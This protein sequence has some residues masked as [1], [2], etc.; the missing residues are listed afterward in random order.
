MTNLV[1][2]AVNS[3]NSLNWTNQQFSKERKIHLLRLGEVIAHL[4][5]PVRKG[6]SLCV[7]LYSAIKLFIVF[8]VLVFLDF[9]FITQIVKNL[10]Y[11]EGK[12][13]LWR[14]TACS[15]V[16]SHNFFTDQLYNNDLILLS[17][18]DWCINMRASQGIYD[19][20]ISLTWPTV[21]NREI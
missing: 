21:T 11:P 20:K 14:H 8:V 16:S 12:T 6:F 1:C 18:K 15:G 17:E 13:R 19:W 4:C 9:L 7:F 2:C 10:S 5:L 3:P